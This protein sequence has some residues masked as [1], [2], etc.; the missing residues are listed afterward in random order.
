M[1]T[2]LL[3]L[4][5]PL[6]ALAAR[7]V[8]FDVAMPEPQ[9]HRFEVTMT[10]DGT[11]G[12]LTVGIP[13]W[14][15]GS[16]LVREFARN[17]E[18]IQTEDDRGRALDIH[19]TDK[20]HWL[21]RAGRS[22]QVKVR[23]R[24]YAFEQSVRT[25]FLD[26]DHA[27][28]NGASVFLYWEGNQDKPHSVH[29]ELPPAWSRISTSLEPFNVQ[30]NVD[31]QAANYDELVDSP[32]ELGNHQVLDFDVLDK[33]HQ[34]ALYGHHDLDESVLV[35]DVSAFIE[36]EAAIFGGLPYEHYVFIIHAGE[37]RG[38]LE[39]AN[40]SVNFIP[41]WS[42]ADSIR[43][44]S[45]ISLLSHEFFHTW[46]IKRI[47]PEGLIRFDYDQETYVPELWIVEGLTSYYDE[48]VLV[49]TGF[50]SQQDYFGVLAKEI[51]SLESRPG[52]NVQ[53]V[54][55][56]GFDAWIKYYRSHADSPNSTV[57]Y[58]NK[59]HL[60]G[61]LLDILILDATRGERSMDDVFRALYAEF[62]LKGR[63]YTSADFQQLC[64]RLSGLNLD[65]FFQQYIY[66][67]EPLPYADGFA[68][69][70]MR[71]D[72]T[73]NDESYLGIRLDQSGGRTMVNHVT[74][75]S[76]AWD[77][78]IN[79]GDELIALDGFRVASTELDYLD[80]KQPGDT[81]SV[82]LSREG[83][84]R[85]LPVIIGKEPD[86]VSGLQPDPN[87]TPEQI[88]LREIWLAERIQ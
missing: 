12:D 46:N 17:I 85:Q 26:A 37:S 11:R 87:A 14:T 3:L 51:R 16:Y 52:K 79:V 6:L 47:A 58:Y 57:S 48:L 38:G 15:P 76:P 25:S 39:H 68:R 86:L 23:Y 43:Y 54:I 69:L 82:T 88:R 9:T 18:T 67:V 53:P 41:R 83:A 1:K 50:T 60:V 13:V 61:L 81:L 36:A 65:A 45:T 63:G 19:K 31:F 30:G 29:V 7:S 10:L 33:P 70:G 66:G 4:F 72:S 34:I 56:A 59:G 32:M 77:A 40:S 64:E 84:L 49:R 42:Y 8:H 73:S 62:Y 35:Q 22:R 5:L 21:I 44:H 71:L 20:N 74:A 28:I 75:R 78:G 2:R 27:L 80:V 24:V 55:D